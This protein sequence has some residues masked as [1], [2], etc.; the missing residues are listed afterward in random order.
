MPSSRTTTRSPSAV[1]DSQPWNDQGPRAVRRFWLPSLSHRPSVFRSRSAGRR[2][3]RTWLQLPYHRHPMRPWPE[4]I[5]EARS[6]HPAA[7]RDRLRC[8]NAAF[9][10]L[11]LIVRP[12]S[13][14]SVRPAWH[15]YVLQVEFTRLGKTRTQVMQELRERGVGTQVHY[16]PVH[17]Q[18]VPTDTGTAMRAASAPL[19][20]AYYQLCLSLPL[21]PAMTDGDVERVIRAVKDAV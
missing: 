15:L 8:Y 19:P 5:E 20:E 7:L 17:L 16:I 3:A 11:P 13:T 10:G 21:Y 4:P 1:V 6:L 2:D 14:D 9:Y 12:V 18:P